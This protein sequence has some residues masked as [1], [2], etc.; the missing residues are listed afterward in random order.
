MHSH[1]LR[2]VAAVLA[3]ALLLAA[4]ALAGERFTDNHDGTITDHHLGLLWSR[5]DNQGDVNWHDA[6]RWAR[7]TFPSALPGDQEGWRLPSMAELQSLYAP[8]GHEREADCGLD[9]RVARA[10]DLSCAF[11]WT[12]E[13]R[14]VTA[15]L[16]NFQLGHTYMDRKVKSRGFRALAVRPLPRD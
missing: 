5:A 9:V 13:S 10:L 12:N 16:F 4:P 6:R 14:N 7:Y 3:C 1:V 8:Q 2:T 15:R 11:V